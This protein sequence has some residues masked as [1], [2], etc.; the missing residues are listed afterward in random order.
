MKI[1]DQGI[2]VAPVD[3]QMITVYKSHAHIQISGIGS[4]EEVEPN[5]NCSTNVSQ[6]LERLPDNEKW[7]G[8]EHH[9]PDNAAAVASQIIRGDAK[10]ISDGSFK[11][12]LGTAACLLLGTNEGDSCS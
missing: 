11:D 2:I 1:A 5:N 6:L 10:A 7:A 4:F 12:E 8:A 9:I 3:L